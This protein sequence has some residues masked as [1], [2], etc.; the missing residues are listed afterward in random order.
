MYGGHIWK[1]YAETKM[2]VEVREPT[3]IDIDC[4]AEDSALSVKNLPK[5]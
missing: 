1:N 2:F 4:D 5:A 3:V